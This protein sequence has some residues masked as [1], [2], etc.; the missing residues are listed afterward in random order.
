MATRSKTKF[1]DVLLEEK[2]RLMEKGFEGIHNTVHARYTETDKKVEGSKTE[3]LDDLKG[4]RDQVTYTNGKVRKIILAL[5]L[6][7]GLIVGLGFNQLAPVLAIIIG[8]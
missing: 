6:A 5:V 8:A 1:P 3:I 7:F 4:I 2:F